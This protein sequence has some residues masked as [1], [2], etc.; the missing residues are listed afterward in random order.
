MT[1]YA[2]V[3]GDENGDEFLDLTELKK[4]ALTFYSDKMTDKEVQN[5]IDAFDD[6]GDRKIC[7]L[8]WSRFIQLVIIRNCDDGEFWEF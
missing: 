3:M 7:Y 6:D 8:E 5:E 1:V 2:F 4:L